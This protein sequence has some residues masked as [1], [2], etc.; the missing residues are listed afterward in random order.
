M[1]NFLL[2]ENEEIISEIFE[3]KSLLPSANQPELTAALLNFRK[4]TSSWLSFIHSCES[5][6]TSLKDRH[7]HTQSTIAEY[8]K[9]QLKTQIKLSRFRS[10]EKKVQKIQEKVA[11]HL[12][13]FP[14]LWNK[15]LQRLKR[16]SVSWRFTPFASPTYDQEFE[17]LQDSKVE[18]DYSVE[19]E[20]V[21]HEISVNKGNC[22]NVSEKSGWNSGLESVNESQN[23]SE[24]KKAISVL[25]KANLLKPESQGV[26]K[27]LTELVKG[28]E[29]NDRL[30]LYLQLLSI[31]N[32]LI[33]SFTE[34][35]SEN[36]VKIEELL[37]ATSFLSS[38]GPKQLE[39]SILEL[40]SQNYSI[41]LKHH[42]KV[43][44]IGKCSTK[45][46]T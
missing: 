27:E 19:F 34:K 18:P 35:I 31:N 23:I 22:S 1:K 36:D 7:S 26:L 17:F 2:Q 8:K 4:L 24:I 25:Q 37:E 29:K 28:P 41:D 12:T 14:Q 44:S 45:E 38:V 39:S 3:L 42:Q 5:E 10:R 11:S 16:K 33:P 21:M 46:M 43:H 9:L 32:S 13:V 20:R 15:N 30:V 40:S 6:K